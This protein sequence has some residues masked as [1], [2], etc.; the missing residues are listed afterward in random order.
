VRQGRTRLADDPVDTGAPVP[1]RGAIVLSADP[2]PFLLCNHDHSRKVS[3]EVGW[4]TSSLWLCG[5]I[6]FSTKAAPHYFKQPADLDC[7]RRIARIT[8][9]HTISQPFRFVEESE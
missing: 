5:A 3:S 6:R 8:E 7:D 1:R 2:D 4:L 9:C